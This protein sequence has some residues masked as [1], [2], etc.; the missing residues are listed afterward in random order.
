MASSPFKMTFYYA[1]AQKTVASIRC[2]TEPEMEKLNIPSN[3]A[4]ITV[5]TPYPMEHEF[6]SD[7]PKVID[8]HNKGYLKYASTYFPGGDIMD[9]KEVLET[10]KEQ[11]EKIEKLRSYAYGAIHYSARYTDETK[12][13]EPDDMHYVRAR[14]TNKIYVFKDN[15]AVLQPI[16]GENT[17][18]IRW[19]KLNPGTLP[20]MGE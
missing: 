19:R 15:D 7:D 6:L 14:L 17:Q 8:D 3:V 20:F 16:K 1:D 11:P 10:L 4:L 2:A 5:E 12:K 18:G 9:Y 13:T